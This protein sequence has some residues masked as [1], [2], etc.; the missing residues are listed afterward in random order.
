MG[1]KPLDQYSNSILIF[2]AGA[3]VFLAGGLMRLLATFP[4][5]EGAAPWATS[6]LLVGSITAFLATIFRKLRP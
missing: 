5:Y 3:L 6:M 2:W 1:L 4:G